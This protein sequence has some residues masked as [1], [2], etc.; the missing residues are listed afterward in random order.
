M[1]KELC[2]I[3]GIIEKQVAQIKNKKIKKT[4]KQD[5]MEN[6]CLES[7]LIK[8]LYYHLYH[9]SNIS[10]AHTHVYLISA[11]EIIQIYDKSNNFL[12]ENDV[13]VFMFVTVKLTS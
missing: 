10:K 2:R 7:T 4:D 11:K 5:I 13:F 3:P 6:I 1:V 12:F 8:Y 9:L